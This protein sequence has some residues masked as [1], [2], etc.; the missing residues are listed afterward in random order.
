MRSQVPL[1]SRLDHKPLAQM[2]SPA[3]TVAIAETRYYPP[4]HPSY[5]PNWGWYFAWAPDP[6]TVDPASKTNPKQLYSQELVAAWNKAN[7]NA[8]VQYDFFAMT[9]YFTWP[10]NFGFA[11]SE[12]YSARALSG[13]SPEP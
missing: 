8:Q 10:R 4:G 7:P 11:S 2:Q 12:S 13:T 6:T 1:L 5:N 9:P 3:S